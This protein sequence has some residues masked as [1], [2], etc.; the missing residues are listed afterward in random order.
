MD[1]LLSGRGVLVIEDEMLVLM[2]IEMM[3]GDLGCEA[4][5]SASTVNAALAAVERGNYDIALLDMNL[6]GEDSHQVADALDARGVPYLFC[7]G[8]SGGDRRQNVRPRVT[9]RKPFA[10]KALSERLAVLLVERDF[11]SNNSVSA[12][13]FATWR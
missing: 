3:L 13:L 5:V 9:L 12:G 7:T 6:A 11:P 8:N 2:M 4:V 10:A 1:K